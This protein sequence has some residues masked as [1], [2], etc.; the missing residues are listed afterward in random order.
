M[1]RTLT[2]NQLPCLTL[3]VKIQGA[4]SGKETSNIPLHPQQTYGNGPNL[5]TVAIC[6][7]K[8]LHKALKRSSEKDVHPYA[9]NLTVLSKQ[10]F[11]PQT[12]GLRSHLHGNLLQPH[13]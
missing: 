13:H 2:V 6:T 12:K 10:S 5:I 1:L 3:D 7:H 9:L 11:A 8:G 4:I